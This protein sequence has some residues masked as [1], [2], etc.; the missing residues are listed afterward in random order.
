MQGRKFRPAVCL[1]SGWQSAAQPQHPPRSQASQGTCR[2]FRLSFPLPKPRESKSLLLISNLSH[3][4]ASSP[5][6]PAFPVFQGG[7]HCPA[8]SSP[9]HKLL[10]I[11]VSIQTPPAYCIPRG[12]A[13]TVPKLRKDPEKYPLPKMFP[14]LDRQCPWQDLVRMSAHILNTLM[15]LSILQRHIKHWLLWISQALNIKHLAMI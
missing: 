1:L 10:H 11:S 4:D 3:T 5:F 15:F 8:T 13:T 12:F 7:R 14:L 6:P 9:P 2:D